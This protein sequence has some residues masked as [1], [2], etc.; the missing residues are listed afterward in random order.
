MIWKGR[1]MD[2]RIQ[3]MK[4]STPPKPGGVAVC[5]RLTR[6]ILVILAGVGLLGAGPVSG[7]GEVAACDRLKDCVRQLKYGET[8]PIREMAARR[9]GE[10]GDKRA[11]E[12]LVFA[13]ERD[14]GEYVRAY[15]ARAMGRLGLTGTLKL[16]AAALR[17]DRQETVRQAA[18]AALGDL[19]VPQGVAPLRAVLAGDAE[20]VVRREAA[21]S[22]GRIAD[23]GGV[24]GLTAAL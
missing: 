13:L 21:I 22:L 16:L 11:G 5:G 14:P 15:A 3:R 7:A 10:L 9:L 24:A 18:A 2:S 6:R 1:D 4:D 8:I 19:G 12:A 20:W 23:P 17:D